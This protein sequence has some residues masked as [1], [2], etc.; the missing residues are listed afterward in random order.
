MFINYQNV[1]PGFNNSSSRD[2]GLIY[3]PLI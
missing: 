2:L 3:A 1:L